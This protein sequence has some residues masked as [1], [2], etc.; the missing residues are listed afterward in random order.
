MHHIFMKAAPML[1]AL[2]L[3]FQP[4]M[5]TE[6]GPGVAKDPL[7][8]QA[9][10]LEHNPINMIINGR[11]AYDLS[12]GEMKYADDDGNFV[13]EGVQPDGIL[14]VDGKQANTLYAIKDKYIGAYEAA[15]PD[16]EIEFDSYH[17]LAVFASYLQLE[18][19]ETQGATFQYTKLDRG[20]VKISKRELQKLMIP[21]EAGYR[22]KVNEMV[23]GIDRSLS[24]K[25]QIDAAVVAV[26]NTFTYNKDYLT[27]TMMTAINQGQGVC[28]HYAK[29]LEDI[30][31]ELG[32]KNEL[33]LGYA[34]GSKAETH[35]WNKIWLSS[36]NRW[37]YSD[38]TMLSQQSQQVKEKEGTIAAVFTPIILDPTYM[39][40]YRMIGYSGDIRP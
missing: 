39:T 38:P 28:Y 11:Y 3:C 16:D 40:Y 23:S 18:Q 4:V 34:A 12:T 8:I 30:L 17:Q 24:E 20:K 9:L 25:E 31:T 32:F 7:E 37:V 2:A 26:A 15:A 21:E 22:D 35:T 13:S 19:S 10:I 27:E 33:I 5:A 1:A 6:G 14:Y 36:E 29:L